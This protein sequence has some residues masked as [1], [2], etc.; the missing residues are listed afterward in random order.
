M[1]EKKRTRGLKRK[2]E[3][4]EDEERKFTEKERGADGE[5]GGTTFRKN[6]G[7]KGNCRSRDEPDEENKKR[8]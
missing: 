5:K 8:C 7:R 4:D 1:R 6:E 3:G 2:E